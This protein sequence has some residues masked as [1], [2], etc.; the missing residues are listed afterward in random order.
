M[1]LGRTAFL[2]F[3]SQVAVSVSGFAATFAIARLGG[4][5][6]LG[7]YAVAVALT[8]WL[9]VPTTA[10]GDALTKRLSEATDSQG[11]V[12]T[13]VL[14][15]GVLAAVI[16]V[17]LLAA[18]PL[19]ESYVGAPVGG[20]VTALVVSNIGL[21][22]VVAVLNG[23]KQVGWSG[24]IKA[25]ERVIRSGIHIGAVVAGFG[26][27]A[28]IAGH[29]V[30]TLLAVVVGTVLS[31]V[32]IGRPSRE[33]GRSLLSYARYAWLGK[34]KTRAFGWMDTIVLAVFV[35]PTLIGVY[36]V[37]WN[38]ASLFALVAV[39]VQTT[40]FPEMSELSGREDSEER[41]HHYLNEGLVFAGVFIIPG[42]FGSAVL[43]RRVLRIYSAEFTQGVE[44]LVLLVVARLLA[45]YGEQFLNAV[46]AVDR[47]DIA[48]RINLAFVA[49]NLVLN[50]ALVATY[51]WLGAA[52]A[53]LVSAGVTAVLS[54]WGLVA[55]MGIPDLPVG[56]FARQVVASGVM[57]GVVL[58]L[59]RVAPGSQ[60][61][62]VGLVFVGVLVYVGCL[63]GVSPRVREK[64][65]NLVR[66]AAAE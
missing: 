52:V 3:L 45:V 35:S 65:D 38:L 14:V 62:T 8:F 44:V 43:G 31:T 20:L 26:V 1:R 37:S 42:L 46:N 28:L 40:L 48:F 32:A 54:Y 5:D 59:R 6:V 50:V 60:Y 24:G 30:A 9:N 7:L 33:R 47:P 25:L 21:V 17:V 56:E 61:A 49:L 13:A 18:R 10:I 34:L 63:L 39:S 51:G 66:S 55:V 16:A 36:E 53:T 19:V 27:A 11:V 2:H 57:A 23:E 29:V 22:T 64:F 58:L 12:A 41:I 15:N 4:A